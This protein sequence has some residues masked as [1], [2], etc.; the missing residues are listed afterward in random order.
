VTPVRRAD[1]AVLAVAAHAVL[2]SVAVAYGS[3]EVV[4]TASDRLSPAQVDDLLARALTQL[5]LVS[6]IL[7][8]LVRGLPPQIVDAMDE[9]QRS[10]GVATA[11]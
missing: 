3:V 10:R 9:L 2:N 8:D 1:D 6:G 11:D 4:R 7:G 5:D